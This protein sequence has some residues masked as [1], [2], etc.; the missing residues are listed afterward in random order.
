M[1]CRPSKGWQHTQRLAYLPF[2]A[3][4]VVGFDDKSRFD[5]PRELSGGSLHIPASHFDRQLWLAVVLRSPNGR[6]RRRLILIE[7]HGIAG[8]MKVVSTIS[9]G[10]RFGSSE[11]Y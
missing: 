3:A 9:R 10:I 11:K 4:A 5:W 2:D 1:R 8:Q 6:R 7:V